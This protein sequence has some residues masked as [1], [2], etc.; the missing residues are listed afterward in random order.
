MHL[1]ENIL[2]DIDLRVKVTWNIAQYPLQYVNYASVKFE[3]ATSNG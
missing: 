2:F 3:V 1:H